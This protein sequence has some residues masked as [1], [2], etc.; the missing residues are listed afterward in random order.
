[1][2]DALIMFD[3]IDTHYNFFV[4]LSILLADLYSLYLLQLCLFLYIRIQSLEFN[5]D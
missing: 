2:E 3:E 5:W 4:F 1:M